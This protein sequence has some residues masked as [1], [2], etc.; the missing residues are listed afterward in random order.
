MNGSERLLLVLR[1]LKLRSLAK[2]LRLDISECA[3]NAGDGGA[4]SGRGKFA[5]GAFQ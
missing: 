4:K 5:S 1:K 3:L 2:A